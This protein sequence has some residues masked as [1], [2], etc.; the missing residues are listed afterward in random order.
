MLLCFRGR[1]GGECTHDRWNLKAQS[2]LSANLSGLG[3][4]GLFTFYCL[5][6][7]DNLFNLR[8]SLVAQVGKNLPAMQETWVRSLGWEDPPEKGKAT[9]SSILAWRDPWTV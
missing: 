4:F 9:H 5:F 6:L 8:T 1:D 2:R 3:S 7:S